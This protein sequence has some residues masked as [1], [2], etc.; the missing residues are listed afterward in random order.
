MAALPEKVR[1]IFFHARLVP[2]LEQQS[3]LHHL[4]KS[5]RIII[6]THSTQATMAAAEK[7]AGST[8]TFSSVAQ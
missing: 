4:H 8:G 5:H 3:T 2:L 6:D 1:S 7:S